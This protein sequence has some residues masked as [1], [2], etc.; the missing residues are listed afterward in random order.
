MLELKE[1]TKIYNKGKK[2]EFTAVKK[3][4]LKM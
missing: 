1:V 4:S 3:C 2:N